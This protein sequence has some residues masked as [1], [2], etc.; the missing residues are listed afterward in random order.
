MELRVIG[1]GY[2]K[3]SAEQPDISA[4]NSDIDAAQV[5]SSKSPHW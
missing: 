5:G 3:W 4:A 1:L 2:V